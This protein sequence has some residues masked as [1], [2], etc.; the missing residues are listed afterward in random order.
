M[1]VLA[2]KL[3]VPPVRA[4]VVA[5]PRLIE[6]LDEGISAGNR[7]TLIS[8][9]AGFGKT[10]V[11]SEWIDTIR[12][13]DQPMQVAWLSLDTGDNDPA[14]FFS[15]L[16]AALRQA[17]PDLD[18]A[19]QT[20]QYS[21]EPLLTALINDSA[22]SPVKILLVLDDYHVVNDPSIRDGVVFLLEHL[23]PT[24]H[25]VI[26]SRSDPSLPLARMRAR[27]E[28][29]ELRAADLRFTPDEAAN[30]LNHVMGLSLTHKDVA[31]LESRTEGW[32]AGLQL[33]A[34]SMRGRTDASAFIA[35]FAGSNRFV[36]DYLIEEVLDRAP[37]HVRRFLCDT[38][39]L[40]RLSGP[41]CD[42]VTGQ[43]GG[44]D[45]L[46]TLERANLFII[47]LDDRREWF[48][49]HHLFA[50]VLRARLA[51][52]GP[53]HVAQLHRRAGEW[54][55][56]NGLPE[57]G[58][59]HAIAAADFTR[60]ARL[61]EQ[62][63]PGVRKSRRDATLLGWLDLLPDEAIT[64]RPVLMVFSAWSSLVVGDIASVEPKLSGAE[65]L[66]C[67][68]HGSEPGPELDTLPVTIALY[69]ASVA[70][71]TGDLDGV[72]HYAGRA[73]ELTISSDH[74]GRGAAAGLLGLGQWASGD[75]EAGVA[76]FKAAAASLRLA[77]NLTD[78]LSTTMVLAD[79]LIPLGRL[80]EARLG[81]ESA[82]RETAE[83]LNGGPPTADLHGGMAEVLVELGDL[84]AAD[85]QLTAG[86]A[87]G[88]AAFS[89]EHHYRWFVSKALL[90]QARGQFDDALQSLDQAAERYRRG[91]FAEA[92][93]IDAIKAR[94]LI[95]QDRLDEAQ[96][97]ADARMLSPDNDLSYLREYAHVTL[98]RLMIA[99]A[100]ARATEFIDRLIVAAETGG[101][102]RIVRELRGLIGSAEH[103]ANSGVGGSF[104][105]ATASG[106]MLSER[107][108]QVLR[109]LATELAGP[110]IAR[111]LFVSLNTLRT[112]TRHVYEKL[113]V[114]S[115]AAAVRLARER[116]LI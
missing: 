3:F 45:M 36:I 79:M 61:I 59:R 114:N 7:L 28:M 74:L 115:R 109:L 23:P 52:H 71:A 60:A 80:D 16:V 24:M 50:E 70:L 5:R 30:F 56:D 68:R 100:D 43:T 19:E 13:R 75:L 99:R 1:A 15:H 17:F 89:H 34:L 11:L 91:F 110:E 20:A 83:D 105:T 6:R 82:L 106:L 107:E 10:S 88:D 97:W 44:R 116:G 76:T 64:D 46:E 58:V 48:R 32:I 94:I 9:P 78:A 12:N 96:A 72:T 33:A 49:Y 63:I 81:Y 14:R 54:F 67:G 84:T 90:S 37:L 113:D 40:D 35:A 53:E 87:L 104:T 101:R 57:E 29:T 21:T 65:L 102:S 112:H 98:A 4:Q 41:L 108:R 77:G 51:A 38:A 47:E 27:G 31:A 73:L 26:A 95:M 93:P 62:L 22:K 92:R 42:A 69:R 55:E 39:I 18:V 25:L 85:D 8:A 2:T 66:L 86:A 103:D 111:E